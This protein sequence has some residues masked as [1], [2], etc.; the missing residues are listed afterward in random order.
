MVGVSFTLASLLPNHFEAYYFMDTNKLSKLKQGI[1]FEDWVGGD[2]G[3]IANFG[4]IY[5]FSITDIIEDVNNGYK[6]GLILK[7]LEDSVD[8]SNDTTNKYFDEKPYIN[9][10]SYAMGLRYENLLK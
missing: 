5:Y 8:A 1:S 4:D 7:W 10:K 9:L 2:I 3:G 6:K